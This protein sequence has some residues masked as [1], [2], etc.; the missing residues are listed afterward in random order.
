MLKKSFFFIIF[1]S[2]VFL[3]STNTL[4]A[5]N[6]TQEKFT[7]FKTDLFLNSNSDP[8]TIFDNPNGIE[9]DIIQNPESLFGTGTVPSGTYKRIRFI[10]KNSFRYTGQNPC[11]GQSVS[12]IGVINPQAA[13]DAQVDIYFATADDG[14]GS[15]WYNNGTAQFPFLMQSPIVVQSGKN[16]TIKLIFNTANTLQ[17]IN[18]NPFLFPPSFNVTSII[19]DVSTSCSITGQWWFVHYNVFVWPRVCSD[20]NCSSYHFP[21]TPQEIFDN[22]SIE[23]GWGTITFNNDGTWSVNLGSTFDNQ[24]TPGMAYHRHNLAMYNPASTEDGYHN[25]A[26]TGTFSGTYRQSGNLITLYFPEGGFIEGAISSDCKTITGANTASDSDNDIIFAV[27]KSTN[28]PTTFPSGK[29]VYSELGFNLCYDVA[30][31]SCYF[32]GDK[33]IKYLDYLNAMGVIDTNL[34]NKGTAINWASNQ[35]Y[36]PQYNESGSLNSIFTYQPGERF[37]IETGILDILSLRNDGLVTLSDERVFFAVGESMNAVFAAPSSNQNDGDDRIKAGYLMKVSNSPTILDLNGTWKVSI[38]ES[39]VNPGPDGNWGTSDDRK[40]YGLNYGEIKIYNGV[41]TQR[42]FIQKNIFDGTIN[43]ETGS[44]ETLQLKTE[45]Y[46]PGAHITTTACS[47]PNSIKIPV[48]Y[49]YG[50]GEM[51]GRVIGKMVLDSSKKTATFWAPID[52]NETPPSDY[53]CTPEINNDYC[54]NTGGH[55]I[56]LF[57]VAVK[58]Q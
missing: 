3:F 4:K 9:S 10:V 40:W 1:L 32:N 5:E 34:G 45:C 44:G 20:S 38:L 12:E 29:Y 28:L 46:K 39:E 37:I 23:E 19:E 49:I 31:S 56:S 58:I 48:F 24:T 26:G 43:N 16:T 14:G 27:K 6:P 30:G 36:I 54:D 50:T 47:D 35:I 15:G 18:N 2:L 42:S 55:V 51:A 21:Q 13:P 7:V 17:C 25:P 53:L 8:I 11:G 33:K 22:T 41:V 57:G 52:L